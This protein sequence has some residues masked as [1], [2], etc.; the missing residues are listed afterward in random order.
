MIEFLLGF[1]F[2]GKDFDNFHAF[3]HL[4]DEAF[5]FCQRLLLSRHIFRGTA[6]EFAGDLEHQ[7]DDCDHD[8]RKP[9]A[10]TDH[11]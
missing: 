1:F 7:E 9:D 2:M 11:R 3:H 4:F 8:K 5:F 6:T 10:V